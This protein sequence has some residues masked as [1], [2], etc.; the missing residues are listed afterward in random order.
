[1]ARLLILTGFGCGTFGGT[2]GG[3][4]GVCCYG[5]EGIRCG[6]VCGCGVMIIVMKSSSTGGLTTTFSGV[7]DR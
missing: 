7:P 6:V 5:V 4:G 3:C 1:M 2:S